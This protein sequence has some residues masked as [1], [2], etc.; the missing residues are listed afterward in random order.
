MV[1]IHVGAA[2]N[3]VEVIVDPSKSVNQIF[4]ENGVTIPA[5]S[6][7]TWNTRRLGDSELEAPLNTLGSLEEDDA[8]I[9]SQKLNGAK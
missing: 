5:G 4:R 6:I 2:F 3:P 9:F 1:R 8:I 7:V